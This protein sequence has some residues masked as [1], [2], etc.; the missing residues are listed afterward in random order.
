M[1]RK[2]NPAAPEARALD[3]YQFE[4][5]TTTIS[6]SRKATRAC[7]ASC[8]PRSSTSRAPNAG[9]PSSTRSDGD[10]RRDGLVGASLRCA[11][12]R[13]SSPRTA[14][15]A[16]RIIARHDRPGEVTVGVCLSRNV[17]AGAERRS[18]SAVRKPVPVFGVAALGA[19]IVAACSSGGSSGSSGEPESADGGLDALT[20]AHDSDADDAPAIVGCDAGATASGCGFLSV[21]LQGAVTSQNCCYGCG[22][23]S[24]GFSWMV[25]ADVGLVSFNLSFAPGQA[26]LEQAGTFPLDNV[27]ITE[28]ADGGVL[29][30]QTPPGACTVTIT[31]SV[32]VVAKPQPEDWLTGSGHCTQPAEPAHGNT[33]G[34]VTIGDFT[35]RGYVLMP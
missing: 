5:R 9:Q 29:W 34:P 20:N 26:P 24:E 23:D 32:C 30:W 3:A 25:L 35:F 10:D 27:T 8:C 16:F 17:A 15:R 13:S 28:D 4:G 1:G 22:A 31:R 6:W 2:A 14:S 33:A 7:F 18:H 11:P 19:V 21:K 12:H